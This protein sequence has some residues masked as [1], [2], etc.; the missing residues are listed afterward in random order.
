MKIK[1]TDSHYNFCFR[2]EGEKKYRYK[3]FAFYAELLSFLE[4]LKKDDIVLSYY[5]LTQTNH[6]DIMED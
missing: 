3:F 4:K 1:K 5:T 2:F 6:F